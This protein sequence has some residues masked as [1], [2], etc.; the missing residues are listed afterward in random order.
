M[1]VA[2][3]TPPPLRAGITM[4]ALCAPI[5]VFAWAALRT[6]QLSHHGTDTSANW[7]SGVPFLAPD[8]DSLRD[9]A[10]L[11]MRAKPESPA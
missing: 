6:Y 7:G 8:A 4:L 2:D 11:R 3:K 9:A 1:K 5:V 10:I